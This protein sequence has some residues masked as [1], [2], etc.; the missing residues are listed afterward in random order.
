[1]RTYS[2]SPFARLRLMRFVR[3]GTVRF[4]M[5]LLCT[6]S[7]GALEP[8]HPR[9]TL[10]P[11][12][13][14]SRPARLPPASRCGPFSVCATGTRKKLAPTAQETNGRRHRRG[15]SIQATAA[16]ALLQHVAEWEGLKDDVVADAG[17]GTWASR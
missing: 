13:R 2:C 15:H 4:S 16:D 12:A 6:L 3:L 14:G 9:Y 10:R 17:V 8:W 5:S 11:A 1:M 7:V